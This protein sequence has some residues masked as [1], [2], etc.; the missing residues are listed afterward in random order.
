MLSILLCT[1]SVGSETIP[2]H[3]AAA[4]QVQPQRARVRARRPQREARRR[5]ASGL[6]DL[7]GEAVGDAR[8]D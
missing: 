3:S 1:V 4:P 8:D 5:S 2:G 6:Q 7:S